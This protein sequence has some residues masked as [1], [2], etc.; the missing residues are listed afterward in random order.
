M[1][2][3][4]ALLLLGAM[5]AGFSGCGL[6][7]QTRVEEARELVSTP[8]PVETP[9]PMETDNGENDRES[10]EVSAAP[11][12]SNNPTS[13]L[14]AEFTI[15]RNDRSVQD[16]NGN[17][18]LKQYYDNVVLTGTDEASQKINAALALR[19]GD[20]L[21]NIQESIDEVNNNPPAEG[22]CYN[23]Y[24]DAEVVENA[25]GIFSI[26][27]TSHWFTG[28]VSLVGIYGLNFNLNTGEFLTLPEVFTLDESEIVAYLKEQT[29]NY[30]QTHP[31]L[32]WFDDAADT[33]QSLTINDFNSL[34]YIQGDTITLCYS[35][36]MLGGSSGC[37]IPCAI[38]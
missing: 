29:L 7:R 5:L 28:G 18:I 24:A 31:G 15:E 33:V 4:L 20:F 26:K 1:K 11:E 25:N 30:I 21:N 32:I 16:E 9:V 23:N 37:T 34:Y 27:M 2:R 10:E 36:Y 22:A 14:S 19:C 38:Q 8:T 6:R 3:L 13:D 17:V 35:T 12:E